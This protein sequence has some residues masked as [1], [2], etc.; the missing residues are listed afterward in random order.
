MAFYQEPS[1]ESQHSAGLAAPVLFLYIAG[2]P[3]L[4]HSTD[5]KDAACSTSGFILHPPV[6][7]SHLAKALAKAFQSLRLLL[8][9][10]RGT[11]A[12]L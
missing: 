4:L 1:S 11:A 8:A 7:L 10:R 6:A 2:R 12:R 5:Q 9:S 3:R